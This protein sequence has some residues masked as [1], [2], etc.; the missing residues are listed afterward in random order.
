MKKLKISALALAMVASLAGCGEKKEDSAPQLLF[1]KLDTSAATTQFA[2]D[3][4]FSSEGV[5]LTAT[6][7]DGSVKELPFSTTAPDMSTVGEGSVT[8]N[9]TVDG[10]QK[11]DSYKINVSY[12]SEADLEIFEENSFVTE[13]GVFPY[14]LGMKVEEGEDGWR[15]VLPNATEENVKTFD[16]AFKKM[17]GSSMVDDGQGGTVEVSYAVTEGIEV[18][19]ETASEVYGLDPE[20]VCAYGIIP[21]FDDD[22]YELRAYSHDEYVIVGLD[23]KNNMIV[24]NTHVA[25]TLETEIGWEGNLDGEGFFIWL[26]AEYIVQYGFGYYDLYG[27]LALPEPASD[28]ACC[29]V[30]DLKVLY[31]FDQTIQKYDLACELG[32][33]VITEDEYQDFVDMLLYNGFKVITEVPGDETSLGYRVLELDNRLN[34]YYRVILNDYIDDYVSDGTTSYGGTLLDILYSAEGVDYEMSPIEIGAESKVLPLLGIDASECTL[35]ASEIEDDKLTYIYEFEAGDMTAEDIFDNYRYSLYWDAQTISE[36][37]TEG[38]YKVGKY[39]VTVKVIVIGDYAI[40]N[41]VVEL[42]PVG[43]MTPLSVISDISMALFGTAVLGDDFKYDSTEDV[44]YLGVRIGQFSY[45]VTYYASIFEYYLL[46]YL[47][48]YVFYDEENQAWYYANSQ[49]T[50]VYTICYSEDGSIA[51]QLYMYKDSSGYV[52]CEFDVYEAE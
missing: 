42:A 49:K 32:L 21:T 17:K 39:L 50:A 13:F 11:S 44:Y 35:N 52:C 1:V 34:G 7:S 46:D 15:I 25:A 27:A 29:S 45:G 2:K 26:L 14:Q 40:V 33:A 48:E 43:E 24:T 3:S 51:V 28:E 41:I 10:E 22:G 18:P 37:G 6:Y 19:E 12:W 36:A 23:A 5:K 4:E 8:V 31:P 9:Y 30:A 16:R 47:P 20:S 38:T